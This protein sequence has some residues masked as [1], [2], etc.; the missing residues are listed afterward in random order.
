M[1]AIGFSG[2]VRNILWLTMAEGCVRAT[3]IFAA[4]ALAY[5][6]EPAV[7][8]AAALIMT[9][10]E[11]MRTPTRNG[12][13][14]S[15]IRASE[16]DTPATLA[17][18]SRLNWI[19]HIG[20]ALTQI[21]MAPVIAGWLETPAL[22]APIAVTAGIFLFYPIVFNRIALLHRAQEMRAIA[23]LSASCLSFANIATALLAVMGF[24]LWSVVIPR[25]FSAALWVVLAMRIHPAP[26]RFVGVPASWRTIFGYGQTILVS[27][28]LKTGRL[29]LDK[30]LIG[31]I[32]GMEALGIYAFAFNAGLGLSQSLVKGFSEAL[33]P[34]LCARGRSGDIRRDASLLVMVSLVAALMLFG[35][36][37]ALA[38]YYVPMLFGDVW[39]PAIP[40]MVVLCLSAIAQPIWEVGAQVVRAEG[41]PG[42]EL[43]WSA[44]LTVATFTSVVCGALYGGILGAAIGIFATNFLVIPIFAHFVIGKP[45]FNI[46]GAVHVI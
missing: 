13:L 5:A 42:R 46:S 18:A 1:Q 33:F 17:T 32:L 44:A 3:R 29:N 38:P 31:K 6:L 36:Q 10:A 15:V 24:G 7:F 45:N 2:L 21:L 25:L 27:E 41:T 30:I 28:L 12:V 26:E 14:Q 35:T 37:A 9:V 23:K 40:V 19:V 4:L 39:S 11:L 43:K 34:W 20:L 22:T 8:G 16:E